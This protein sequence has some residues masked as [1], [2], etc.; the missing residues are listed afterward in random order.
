VPDRPI[1][2]ASL[3]DDLAR[4]GVRRGSVLLLH[5]SLRSL[6]WVVG[7][8]VAVVQALLDLLGTQGTLVAPT[9]TPENSDPSGWSRPP[10]PQ[11]W[12][13]IIRAHMPAFDPATTP[14]RWMGAIAEV[15]RTWPGARRSDHPQVSFAALG[16][17]AL[18]IVADHRL[19]QALGE[20][21]PV[22][23]VYELDGDVLLLG[24]GHDSNTS[25]H[26]AEYRVASPP[27]RT[28]AAAV[29]SAEG[30][31]KWTTWVDVA[32]NE[33]D[34]ARLGADLDATGLVRLGSVAKASAR[35]MRQ[36]AAVDFAV[37]WFA[38]HR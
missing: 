38:Q 35:F 3:A 22:G 9:H 33:D 7:G 19:D 16:P 10:V 11:E 26:L 2:R 36:R 30:D 1:T 37:E 31:Q 24:V 14:S 27:Q 34:F 17:A 23:R 8:P 12:W 32:V 5:S 4:L 6:G 21:S 18:D 25:L 20:P 29:R 15:I 13:P 28:E